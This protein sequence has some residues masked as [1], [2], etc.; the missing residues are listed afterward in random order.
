MTEEC[1]E[2][3]APLPI[4]PPQNPHGPTLDPIRASAMTGRLI[5]A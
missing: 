3:I 1:R 4:R 5:V 2:K